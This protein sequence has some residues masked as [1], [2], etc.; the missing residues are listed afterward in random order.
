VLS[1]SLMG[2]VP[3][4]RGELTPISAA[5]S[6]RWVGTTTAAAG[7]PH[8]YGDAPLDSEESE[9][10]LFH[11][12]LGSLTRFRSVILAARSRVRERMCAQREALEHVGTSAGLS[13]DPI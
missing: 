8:A 1:M 2:G 11:H 4:H 7:R 12:K 13:Q 3:L 6:L 10:H 5:E 9:V